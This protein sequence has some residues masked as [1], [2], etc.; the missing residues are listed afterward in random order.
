MRRGRAGGRFTALA[1]L[2]AAV[3]IG[4]G[5]FAAHGASGRAAAWLETG[6]FYLLV[7]AVAAMAIMS[8]GT[9]RLARGPSALLLGGAIL[10]SGTLFLMA[11]GFPRMLGAITPVGGAAMIAGWLWLALRALRR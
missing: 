4:C 11:F 10:F 8:S 9:G 7:H 2:S 3:A 6:S 5:A 1:A